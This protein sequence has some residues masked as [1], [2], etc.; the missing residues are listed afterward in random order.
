M[1]SGRAHEAAATLDRGIERVRGA[2]PALAA[3]LEDDLFDG[4]NYD[5]ELAQERTRRLASAQARPAVLAHRAFDRA[6][7]GASASEVREL[8]AAALADGS[9]SQRSEQPAALYAIEALMAVEAADEARAAIETFADVARRTGSRVGM[10]GIAMARARWE[11][12]FGNLEAA[13]EAARVAIEIQMALSGGGA[14]RSVR[15]SLAASLLDAGDIDEAERLLGDPLLAPEPRDTLLPIC[16]FNALR[17]RILLERGRPR[18]ALTE[19]EAHIA[20]EDRRGWIASFRNA[21]RVTMITAL[22]EA[23]RV[24]EARALA[25]A[26]LTRARER[27][28]HG[29]EARV[30]VAGARLALAREAEIGLLEQ[31]VAAARRSPSRLILAEA[32]TAYGATLRRANRRADARDPLREARELALQ[33]GAKALEKHA[34]DELVIA[35]ARPQRVAQHGPEGLTPSERRVAELAAQGHR[36]RD[37]A[38]A[39]FV[40]AKTVEVH[41]GRAYTKLGIS[42]RSQLADTLRGYAA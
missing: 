6:A 1:I 22:A 41:L 21:T 12:E 24:D 5:E 25:D 31:A 23:G 34:H 9:L 38:E 10:G 11:H 33:T 30:L 8:A 2:D 3:E 35:G 28:L 32:L 16:G 13:Q 39:L 29:H 18:E 14:T 19:L 7:V 36:N 27:D 26:Q 20:L 17:G 4:L 15:A 40:T 42:S 37:I